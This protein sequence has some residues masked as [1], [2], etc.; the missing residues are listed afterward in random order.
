MNNE[1]VFHVRGGQAKPYRVGF[2]V[3]GSTTKSTCTCPSGLNSLRKGMLCK[4]RIALLRG[5][6]SAVQAAPD[7]LANFTEL[8]RLHGQAVITSANHST[9][10][11]KLDPSLK[12]QSRNVGL[13]AFI[14]LETTGFSADTAAL[15]QLA[16]QLIKH[17]M[18]TGEIIGCIETYCAMQ[19]PQ[20]P[21]SKA[22]ARVNKITQAMVYGSAIQWTV[23]QQMVDRADFLVAHNAEFESRFL[24]RIPQLRIDKPW[25]CSCRIPDWTTRHGQPSGKLEVLAKAHGIAHTAHSALGDVIATVE[26]L[27]MTSPVTRKPYFFDLLA[28]QL[29][30]KRR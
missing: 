2:L 25:R 16:I 19:A 5:D 17:D 22:A 23:V 21:M 18:E 13:A 29:V 26:L 30:G 6:F 1:Y 20:G 24:S 3:S 11:L 10:A 27:G 28:A 8:V 4:H 9:T 12:S 15:L 14:D 7:G